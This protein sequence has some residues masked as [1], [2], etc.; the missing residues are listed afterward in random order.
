MLRDFIPGAS[1]SGASTDPGRGFPSSFSIRVIIIYWQRLRTPERMSTTFKELDMGLMNRRDFLAAGAAA[2][3]TAAA[4]PLS[5]AVRQDPVF[6]KKI[7][8]SFIGGPDENTFKKAKDNGF[9]GVQLGS[10]NYK[11]DDARKA[12]ETA[13]KCGIRI[14]SLIRAW[15]ALD[16]PNSEEI[17][18]IVASI[19]TAL[20]AAE[21][22]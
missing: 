16:S 20:L 18:K 5:A 2:G 4:R 12:R 14:C 15:V 22:F 3:L 10:W 1:V 7:K 21:A 13:E 8:K 19:E 6:K 9:D 11:P 17:D